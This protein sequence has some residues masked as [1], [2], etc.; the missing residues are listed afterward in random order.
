MKEKNKENKDEKLLQWHAAFYAG[1]QIELEDEAQY[2]EFENEHMLSS[3]PM[4]LDVLIIK[5]DRERQIK[6]NIGR[7]FRTY[8]IIEYKSPDD[9]L[10]IDD[11]YK[12]YG[13]TCFY[14]SDTGKVDEIKAEELT[15]TFVCRMYPR[16]LVKYLKMKNRTIRKVES[17]IYYISDELFQIQLI[18]QKHLS[19]ETNLWLRSL[20]NDLKERQRTEHLLR[21][22]KRHENERLYRS[23]M[24]IIV[25]ANEERFKVTNM[26]DALD[27]I[28]EYHFKGKLEAG[29]QQGLE[30]G[31]QEGRQKG[32]LEGRLEGIQEGRQEGRLEGRLEGRQEGKENSLL[33]LISKKLAKGKQLAQIAEELETTEEAILPLYNKAKAVFEKE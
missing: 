19:E 29:W 3:K 4:Q 8:N 26:C 24:E 1:I 11:F 20:T 22:Y 7:I 33:E 10:S 21:E 15:I 5:K 12:V 31:L 28:L 25:R 18:V 9:S 6:K 16:E 13:Y 17:G 23:V 2:L 32:L 14:K 30:K 27:E